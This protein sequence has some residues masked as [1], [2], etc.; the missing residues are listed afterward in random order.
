[1][2]NIIVINDYDELPLSILKIYMYFN[3]IDDY[4]FLEFINDNNLLDKDIKGLKEEEEVI[5]NNHSINIKICG[6]SSVGKSTFI[7]NIL[8]EKRA[9]IGKITGTTNRNHIYSCKEYN[10]KFIDD[11]GFD[12]GTE[13]NVNIEIVDLKNKK[14]T[15]IMDQNIKLSYGYNNDFRNNFHLLLYF[16]KL[17][18]PYNIIDGQLKYLKSINDAKIPIIFIINFSDENIL[19]DR[20]E[21]KKNKNNCDKASNNYLLIKEEIES[22][23]V[24]KNQEEFIGNMIIPI[25]CQDKKGFSDLFEEI[26]NIFKVNIIGDDILNILENGAYNEEFQNNFDF[27]ELKK[28]FFLKIL[29]SKIL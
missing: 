6:S 29:Y 19:I 23:L 4:D 7:N 21:Y 20:K 3:Q 17:G 27:K 26:Y 16:F 22:Q 14:H 28:I 2:D 11:L 13:G 9:L 24:Q 8:G 12:Q 25:N 18:N 15:I 10:L 5:T 1:M